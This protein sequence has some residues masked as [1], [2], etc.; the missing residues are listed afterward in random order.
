VSSFTQW[1]ITEHIGLSLF[2]LNMPALGFWDCCRYIYNGVL[3]AIA[4]V[5]VSGILLFLLDN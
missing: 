4:G 5:F 1:L 2:L 3:I